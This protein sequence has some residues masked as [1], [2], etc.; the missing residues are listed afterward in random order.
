MIDVKLEQKS[1]IELTKNS[2]GYGWK[3]K[4]YSEDIKDIPK[5]LDEINKDMKRKFKNE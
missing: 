5:I 2:K 1:S 4:V 3:L